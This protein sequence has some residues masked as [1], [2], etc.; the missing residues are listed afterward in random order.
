MNSEAG[1]DHILIEN[2]KVRC[3]IGIRPNERTRKQPL[4]IDI[5]ILTDLSGAGESDS[6][7]DTIDYSALA[8]TIVRRLESSS[9]FLIEK[10]AEEIA[11]LCLEPAIASNATVRVRKPRA[12]GRTGNVAVKIQRTKLPG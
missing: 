9:W 12:L 2:L 1:R 8:R 7:E 5:D 11:G 3:V 4:L 10:A 6:I